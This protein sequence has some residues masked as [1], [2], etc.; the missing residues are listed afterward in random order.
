SNRVRIKERVQLAASA[1][2]YIART[3]MPVYSPGCL[4]I[5]LGIG[6]NALADLIFGSRVA[7][8]VAAFACACGGSSQGDGAGGASSA[9]APATGGSGSNGVSGSTATSNPG[10]SAGSGASG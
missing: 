2:A 7:C 1:G 5:M 8:L 3:P 6:R 9:G 10:G 4:A